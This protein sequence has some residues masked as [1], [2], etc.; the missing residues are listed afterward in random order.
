VYA[1]R[2]AA[3]RGGL[4][5]PASIQRAIDNARHGIAMAYDLDVHTIA[6]HAGDLTGTGVNFEAVCA[7][8]ATIAEDADRAGI[9]VAF[10]AD[11]AAK[12]A[13]LLK[14]VAC[15]R[16][17]ANLDTA[18]QIGSGL[19]PA[20]FIEQ[21]RGSIGQVTLADSVRAGA[22]TRIVELGHGQLAL[23]QLLDAL[24]QADF[25]GPL[26]V[27]VRDLP[28]AIHAAANAAKILRAIL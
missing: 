17:R 11:D 9:T 23:P 18:R 13:D 2:I 15:D 14:T 22:R 6:V 8:A 10:G 27:D 19:D 4:A 16:A 21:F 25:N 28:D 24:R 1:L 5:D 20:A 12:L 7:A 3:P 26:V